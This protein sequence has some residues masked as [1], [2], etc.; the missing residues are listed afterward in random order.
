[1]VIG[2][3]ASSCWEGLQG[4]LGLCECCLAPESQSMGCKAGLTPGSGQNY[5]L[6]LVNCG[7]SYTI[8]L[9]YGHAFMTPLLEMDFKS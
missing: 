3:E 6:I 7:I 9:I 8:A 5:V 4:I 1:M 2:D